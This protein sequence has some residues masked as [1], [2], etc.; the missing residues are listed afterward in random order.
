MGTWIARQQNLIDFTLS[1]LSRRKART[2]VLV[3]VYAAMVFLLASVMLFTQALRRDAARTLVDAPDV[4]VQRLTAGRHDAM[5]A[6]YLERLEGIRGISAKAGRLW[7][8]Y[9]DPITR[10]NYTVLVPPAG[11][12]PVPSGHVVVGA[13]VAAALGQHE[14]SRMVWE[15]Y[16]GRLSTLTI[17]RIL[18]K[19]SSVYTADVVAIGEDDFRALFDYPAGQ[20]TDLA[21]SVTNPQEI[22]TIAAKVTS[23]LP[24]TRV[25]VRDEILR[26]YDAIFNWREG[27][28]LVVLFGAVIAFA[29]LALDKA[30]GL[31]ADET[32]EVGI[33]KAVGWDTSDVIRMK[34]WEGALLS[35]A[36]FGCGYLA[37]YV[38]V[39]YASAALFEPVLRGW[40]VLSPRPALIP[41]IDGLQVATLLMFTVLP[42]TAATI[43]PIWRA[44]TMD[45]DAVMRG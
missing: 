31:T 42:Y 38:H 19:D 11:G 37:A 17:D 40:S 36:A 33:L 22:G 2:A 21:V 28:V 27:I 23:R 45:P 13:S 18:P 10:A 24:D 14:G 6:A 4:I 29:I 5:P 8:Y 26:T 25:I 30:S 41:E 43:L 9:Y 39:F 1:S 20:Y 44:A 15:A 3:G 16:T 7:G 32:R 34:F 35:L 12:L